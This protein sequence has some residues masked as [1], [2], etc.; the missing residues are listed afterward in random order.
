V[1]WACDF[2]ALSFLTSMDFGSFFTIFLAEQ[3]R[4]GHNRGPTV[5]EQEGGV[6]CQAFCGSENPP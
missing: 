4:A 3:G 6:S 1:D 5:L 2:H